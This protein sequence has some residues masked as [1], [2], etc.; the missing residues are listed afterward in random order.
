M[1]IDGVSEATIR[2]AIEV[3]RL[4]GPGLLQKT[5]ERC[6]AV[7]LAEKPVGLLINFNVRL[8]RDGL[9]RLTRRPE[10]ESRPPPVR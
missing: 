5:Y 3:H 2:A 9:R 10:N 4:L 6:L 8:L 7:E 1:N